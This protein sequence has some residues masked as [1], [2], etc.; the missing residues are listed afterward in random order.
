MLTQTIRIYSLKLDQPWAIA[1]RLGPAGKG[2]SE[3]CCILLKL[4]DAEG[5]C[6]FGEAAPVTTYG[7]TALTVISFLNKFDW[8]KVSFADLESSLA[9]LHGSAPG[10]HAAKAAIDLALHDGAAK[11][12]RQSL[13]A[14]LGLNFD[15]A[16]LP[17]SSYSIGLASPQDIALRAEAGAKFP[18]I[19]LKADSRNLE[20]SLHAFRS[21]SP[22][23]PLR[24]DGNEAW[25]TREEALRA[26]RLIAD[27]GPIEFVEQPMPRETSLEDASWLKE[28]SPLTLVADESFLSLADLEYCSHAFHGVNVKLAK[29]GGIA[30]AKAL[31]ESAKSLGLK[32]QLGC[33]IETSLGIAAA[34]Q[35]GGLADWLDLD[36][37][38]LTS[39]DPFSGLM[40]ERGQLSFNAKSQAHGLRVQ[41][42]SGLWSM[43]P[44]SEKPISKRAQTPAAHAVYGHSVNGIPL[45]VHLPQSGKC[46]LLIFAA[47]HGEEPETTTLLS[48]A[49][50]SL[51]GASPPC[52]TV[53]CANPDGTLLG[54]RGNAN[55]VELNRNF[56]T[57]NWQSEPISTKW[58]PTHGHVSF[59]T[60]SEAG[61]EPETQALVSLVE[62]LEPETIISLHA[63]LACIE[64]PGYSPLGYWLSKRTGL[65]LVGD[66]GYDTPGSFGSWA[67]EN[68]WH[69]ITY[70]LPPSSVS[71]L[72]EKHLGN[73]ID[74][75]SNGLKAVG[76]VPATNR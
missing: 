66:I 54:T 74:L 18:I 73:L 58:S 11:A 43:K 22:H 19:K 31:L 53:L 44:P 76:P 45:E 64:D 38:L 36:G 27:F 50:R 68:G 6:G 4:E 21:V 70:E 17:P 33:M 39:N 34:L 12:S 32:T 48:K 9:Y 71:A 40:E 37:S 42:D 52:A 10:N 65:P 63:P 59:S 29:S 46:E 41:P 26:I 3:R 72:H 23:K 1:S 16:T 51:D 61:S 60:G 2:I 8:S 13:A 67:K 20:A 24:I 14:S 30:P 57:S 62:A 69:V 15:P 55:G 49:L 5:N 7:E 75:L 35:L 47:I 28:H 25:K 56:P